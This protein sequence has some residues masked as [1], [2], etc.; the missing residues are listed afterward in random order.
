MADPTQLLHKA[1]IA[2]LETAP[3]VASGRIYGRVQ[4]NATF[5][6]VSLGPIDTVGD[7]NSCFDSSECN[8]QVNV[9]SNHKDMRE[10]EEIAGLVRTRL[11]T[12]PTLTGFHVPVVEYVTTRYLDDP[13]Q[14]LRR[15]ALEFRYLIDHSYS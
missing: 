10:V 1:I 8:V 5:P 7:D 6:Y 14:E 3:A 2:A 11:K 13:Q 12:E 15:A 9:W 4:P